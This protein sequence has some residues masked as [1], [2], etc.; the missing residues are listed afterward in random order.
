M[1]KIKFEHHHYCCEGK[2]CAVK[3]FMI[4]GKELAW[5][6][7]KD[8]VTV[9]TFFKERK[10]ILLPDSYDVVN[11]EETQYYAKTPEAMDIKV[12]HSVFSHLLGITGTQRT[13]TGVLKFKNLAQKKFSSYKADRL[14]LHDVITASG[15]GS[16]DAPSD[17]P[18]A[19][20]KA[21]RR[22]GCLLLVQIYYTNFEHAW[23]GTTDIKYTY[24]VQRVPFTPYRS[25]EII[26]LLYQN[27]T[28]YERYSEPQRR[29]LKK[30]YG[31][32]VKFIQSGKIGSFSFFCLIQCLA[33]S[34]SLVTLITT[35]GDLIALY[36]LPESAHYREI[37]YGLGDHEILDAKKEKVFK[38][39]E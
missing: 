5:P 24:T 9:A 35:V 10:Q 21:F 36:L 37:I 18:N 8:S 11:E 25:E 19:N 1:E 34:M 6:L 4:D 14:L 23:F 30:R 32:H 3:C 17:S 12:E 29:L 31:V 7:D 26:P 15:M 20:N 39:E 2:K 38:K 27:K 13:M 16:L 28:P 22:K 33:T